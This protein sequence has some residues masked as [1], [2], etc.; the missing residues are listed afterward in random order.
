MAAIKKRTDDFQFINSFLNG[1]VDEVSASD[2]SR[3]HAESIRRYFLSV[4]RVP[5][6]ITIDLAYY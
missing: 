6:F 3:P 1:F 5:L 2:L 4:H